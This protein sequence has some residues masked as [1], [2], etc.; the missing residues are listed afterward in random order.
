MTIRELIK[1]I[2]EDTFTDAEIIKY[3]EGWDRVLLVELVNELW[4]EYYSFDDVGEWQKANRMIRA[5]NLICERFNVDMLEQ[6]EP[7]QGKAEPTRRRGRPKETFK[8]KMIDDADGSKLEKL[9][10]AIDGKKGKFVALA[11]KAGVKIGRLD[12]PSYTQVRNE[13]G[14]IGNKSGFN[15]YMNQYVF[16]DEEIEGAINA[17]K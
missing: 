5:Y 8:D 6:P 15:R 1:E 11:I 13:F 16:T 17:I 3:C 14:D 12:K 9:H 4:T 2:T 10:K 7:Q